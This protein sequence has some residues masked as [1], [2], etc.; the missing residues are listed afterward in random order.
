VPFICSSVLN[1]VFHAIVVQ[2][3]FP[4]VLEYNV[5]LVA[6]YILFLIVYRYLVLILLVQ[7]SQLIGRFTIQRGTEIRH[8]STQRFISVND[9]SRARAT[10]M[11]W[12]YKCTSRMPWGY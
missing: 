6:R 11:R 4:F 1:I 3:K 5:Q 12:L 8:R 10:C 2:L 9:Y 7:G